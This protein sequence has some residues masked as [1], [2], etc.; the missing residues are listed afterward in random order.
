MT[1]RLTVGQRTLNPRILVRIQV[2]Q[3]LWGVAPAYILSVMVST[4]VSK[5][6]SQ[7]S[8]PW[9]YATDSNSNNI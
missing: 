6:I 7:G 2:G 3:L 8:N 5:A 4:I 9:G 1:H